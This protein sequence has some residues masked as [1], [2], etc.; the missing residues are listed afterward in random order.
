MSSA[1]WLLDG[2]GLVAAFARLQG[3]FVSSAR[4]HCLAPELLLSHLGGPGHCP[5]HHH[6]LL[7]PQMTPPGCAGN[8]QPA[9]PQPETWNPGQPSAG[10]LPLT[11]LT[12]LVWGVYRSCT[13]CR[14]WGPCWGNVII[15]AVGKREAKKVS[16]GKETIHT[17]LYFCLRYTLTECP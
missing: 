3:C 1:A 15:S 11:S 12:A 14:S 5:L 6:A 8:P 13:C 10:H 7:D 17:L 9:Q 2:S 4:S 16:P